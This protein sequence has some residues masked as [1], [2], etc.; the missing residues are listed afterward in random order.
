MMGPVWDDENIEHLAKHGVDPD[1]ANEVLA[2][3]Q[4]PFPQALENGK[5]LAW[6]QT[7]EGRFLQ[8]I[9]VHRTVQSLDWELLN[10]EDRMAL[11]DYDGV[12]VLYVI[13]ARDLT[14]DEK[15]QLRRRKR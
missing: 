11:Q 7:L 2:D 12:E 15:R 1:E 5:L 3:M 8:I 6:G 4:P 13:H 9:F 14:P 10:W